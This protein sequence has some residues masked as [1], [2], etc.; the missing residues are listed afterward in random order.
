MIHQAT[1]ISSDKNKNKNKNSQSFSVKLH[2][3]QSNFPNGEGTTSNGRTPVGN[4]TAQ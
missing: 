4:E 1:K 2:T 3:Q